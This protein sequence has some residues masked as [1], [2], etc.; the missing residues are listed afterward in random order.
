MGDSAANDLNSLRRLVDQQLAF[1]KLQAQKLAN[2]NDTF[3][4]RAFAQA[5]LLQTRIAIHAYLREL[6][7]DSVPDKGGRVEST[8]MIFN[9]NLTD[10][11]SANHNSG[12]QELADLEKEEEGW[13]QKLELAICHTEGFEAQLSLPSGFKSQLFHSPSAGS[14]SQPG[15]IIAVSTGGVS[16][17]EIHTMDLLKLINRLVSVIQRQRDSA[18]EY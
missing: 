3:E 2:S 5:C 12:L 17:A 1:S 9:R 6:S 18:I 4:K 14:E 15:G 8:W 7:L 10:K 13:L 11:T 16:L